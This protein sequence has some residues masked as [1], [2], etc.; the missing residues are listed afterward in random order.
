MITATSTFSSSTRKARPDDLLIRITVANRGPAKANLQLLP[1]FWFRNTWSWGACHTATRR[2]EMRLAGEAVIASHPTLG[3][4][5]CERGRKRA[6][7]FYR[8]R[9]ERIAALRRA[10]CVGAFAKDGFHDY[11]VDGR[12]DGGELWM[13]ERRPPLATSSRFE[14]NASAVVRLRLR[15]DAEA[16]GAAFSR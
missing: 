12:R 13:R 14:G 5:R 15:P 6:L 4:F 3:E 8:E 11:V 2:P 10:E 1:T 7:A 16:T 9:D